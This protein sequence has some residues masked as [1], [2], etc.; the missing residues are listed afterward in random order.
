MTRRWRLDLAR[1]AREY[2]RP[3]EVPY[4]VVGRMLREQYG[5]IVMDLD[6]WARAAGDPET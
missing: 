5:S 2:E 1:L 6:W 4:L 3:S